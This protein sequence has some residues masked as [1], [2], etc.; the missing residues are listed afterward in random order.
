[1]RRN[2][3]STIVEIVHVAYCRVSVSDYNQH[4]YNLVLSAQS[5]V[6]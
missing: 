3:Y 1:M 6:D 4:S 2:I 5:I